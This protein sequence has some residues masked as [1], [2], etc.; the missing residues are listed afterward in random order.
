MK[1]HTSL[2]SFRLLC[3]HTH[4]LTTTSTA[5]SFHVFYVMTKWMLNNGYHKIYIFGLHLLE[6]TVKVKSHREKKSNHK[7]AAA[8][9]IFNFFSFFMIV[10][11]EPIV[12]K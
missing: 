5:T 2:S 3:E 7:I 11:L 12:Q 9:I 10:F 8:K 1:S 4:S 6:I